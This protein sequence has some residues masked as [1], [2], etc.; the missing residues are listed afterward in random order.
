M[1]LV[2]A[3]IVNFRSIK[4]LEINFSPACR[5]LVGINESGKTNILKA[6]A[7]LDK[8]KKIDLA[9]L[10]YPLQG[11]SQIQES[12]IKFHFSLNDSQISE[13]IQDSL[14]ELLCSAKSSS[15]IFQFNE[16]WVGL[17][18]AFED[19]NT[20]FYRV[21]ILND[22]RTYSYTVLND[23]FQYANSMW[24][25]PNLSV[26]GD[27]KVSPEDLRFI[28]DFAFIN[29]QDYPDIP[30]HY[31]SEITHDDWSN[32]LGNSIVSKLEKL[33][34]KCI[35]WDYQ[36]KNLL[37]SSIDLNA[38]LQNPDSCLPLKNMFELMGIDNIQE[39][40]N[41]ER[42]SNKFGLRNLFE[43]VGR[44]A[45]DHVSKV[46]KECRD[47]QITLEPNGP[48]TIEAGIKDSFNRFELINRSDGFKRFISFLIMIS[49][50]VN[51]GTLENTLIL[52]DEPENGLHPSGAR[53]LQ[54]ELVNISKNNAVVFSTHSIF[55]IDKSCLERQLIVKKKDEVTEAID[56]NTSNFSDEE[57]IYNALGYSI[58]EGLS[59]KNILFEGWKDKKLFQVALGGKPP[60]RHSNI[61]SLFK[62]LGVAHLQGASDARRVAPL[63][64]LANRKYL[65]VSDADDRAKSEQ[66]SFNGI[67]K[68]KRW[69]EI[70]PLHKIITGE[71]FIKN[72]FVLKCL[73]LALKESGLSIEVSEEDLAG[74]GGKIAAID[75]FL[76]RHMQKDKRK[77]FIDRLKD[78]MANQLTRK[79]LED[80]FYDYLAELPSQFD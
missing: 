24:F 42:S 62:T 33:F 59:E 72:D 16:K 45:T 78:R 60:E 70:S 6:L 23:A 18:S 79:D 40:I 31:F 7:F 77:P 69:D 58:F 22:K 48:V 4:N 37:P 75:K 14:G 55:M 38:F 2:K 19:C 32:W 51:A 52:I 41:R 68:W 25:K 10:R 39:V 54:K 65:I 29:A 15:K 26:V 36:D 61:K 35:F 44:T 28:K 20:V 3:E 43:R 21:D 46:W 80:Y 50:K 71:D 74:N 34:P 17:K 64:E 1:N 11:E 73:R 27:A 56:V 5:T 66:A 67:G 49:A 9:D 13:L 57:V 12:Y 53:Y 63:L 30:T 76:G 47:L 8:N